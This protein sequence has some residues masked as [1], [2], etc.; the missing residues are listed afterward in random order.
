MMKAYRDPSHSELRCH[1]KTESKQN[2][3]GN[4]VHNTK[5]LILLVKNMLCSILHCQKVLIRFSVHM[6]FG[7]YKT[8]RTKLWSRLSGK[9]TSTLQVAILLGSGPLTQPTRQ[10][11]LIEPTRN[12]LLILPPLRSFGL[13]RLGAS[14]CHFAVAGVH[15]AQKWGR[16]CLPTNGGE[17]AVRIHRNG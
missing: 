4:E 12:E 15:F 13:S 3:S 10:V 2:F 6:K 1:K 14:V 17:V 5:T 16:A 11:F 9:T 7:T 8:V